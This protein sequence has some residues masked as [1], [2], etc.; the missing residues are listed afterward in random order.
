MA[1]QTFRKRITTQEYEKHRGRARL[2]RLENANIAR[3]IPPIPPIRD[4]A[5]RAYCKYNFR[6]FCEFYFPQTFYLNWSEDH[7]RI[8][9][10]IEEV[11]L[12][13]GQFALAMPRGSGKSSLCEAAV[14]WASVYGH[15]KFPILIGPEQTHVDEMIASIKIEYETNESLNDDFPEVCF[16]I[17]EI[18]GLTQR[19]Y[20][21]T[22]L[23]KRTSITWTSDILILPTINQSACSGT[24]IKGVGLLGKIRGTKHKTQDGDTIRPDL[25]LVDDPQ[26]DASARSFMQNNIR[27][28][29]IDRAVLGLAGPKKKIAAIAA[30]T[31]IEVNDLCDRMLNSEQHPEWQGERTRMLISEPKNLKLW[32][33]YYAM[34]E[35]GL[36]EK[37]GLQKANDFYITNREKMDEGAKVS[38][39]E[40]FNP[41][42]ISGIQH[43]MNIKL[44]KP[45]VFASEYQNE[46]ER[47]EDLHLVLTQERA[48]GKLSGIDKSIC[49][50]W[51]QYVTAFI[52]V[53]DY[54]LYYAVVAWG[55]DFSGSII[56]YGTFPQQDIRVFS[57][58]ETGVKSLKHLYPDMS[59]D[60]YIRAGLEMLTE[61]LLT[62][63][64]KRE[65]GATLKI[66]RCLVDAG[67][68]SD[69]IEEFCRLNKFAGIILPSRGAPIG[70]TQRKICEY[71][72]KKGEL[73]G[74]NWYITAQNAK[75]GRHVRFD[76]N[77]FKSFVHSRFL[78]PFG[79]KGCLSLYGRDYVEH[80]LF[81]RH[82]LAERMTP[83]AANGR[84]TEVW[85]LVSRSDN[86]YFDCIVGA[87]VAGSMVGA[88]LFNAPTLKRAKIK[89]VSF[90]E[91]AALAKKDAQNT[92]RAAAG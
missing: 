38:W 12:G 34:R 39:P 53:H 70:P 74:W 59:E 11:V 71:T 89:R 19:A 69:L 91:M 63:T 44:S 4:P 35:Q 88:K 50:L 5:R 17:R 25:V 43:A 73:H 48:Y 37:T 2:K 26:T 75:L 30:I 82:L 86:H 72:P 20:G 27:E 23:G 52:D 68:K 78:T 60:G 79:E 90:A 3:D 47:Q 14:I 41:D 49:P 67:Y 76:T 84:T 6:A 29:V 36:K 8:I 32:D 92:G 22:Y 54:L 85:E 16:P 87:A 57:M 46:P 31:V 61:V 42:E 7:L 55:E 64:W 18:A 51:A 83:V 10:K 58:K 81:V 9:K 56:H 80:I 21:Q 77:F 24:I 65:D 15:R 66:S 1:R 45:G 62:Q 33:E 13:G 28:Q 40:R